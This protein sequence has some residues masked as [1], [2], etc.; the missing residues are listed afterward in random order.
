MI[1]KGTNFLILLVTEF[2]MAISVTK[3][4]FINLYK[5]LVDFS[6]GY[7]HY[8]NKINEQIF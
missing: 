2:M 8:K 4:S 6:D 1:E 3:K 5:F 7:I